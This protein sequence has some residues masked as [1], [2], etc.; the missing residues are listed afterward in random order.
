M[1]WS[2]L[3]RL[4]IGHALRRRPANGSAIGSSENQP[5]IYYKQGWNKGGTLLNC[6]L[7]RGNLFRNSFLK[8]ELVPIHRTGM[9]LVEMTC[10]YGFGWDFARS[11]E[12]LE[13]SFKHQ[14]VQWEISKQ[15][16]P[17][18]FPQNCDMRV[19]RKINT[20]VELVWYDFMNSFKIQKL[21]GPI[22]GSGTSSFMENPSSWASMKLQDIGFAG[23]PGW[24]LPQE[25]LGA[26]GCGDDMDGDQPTFHQEFDERGLSFYI[27]NSGK[28][29]HSFWK[30]VLENISW[31]CF[32]ETLVSIGRVASRAE[33]F[34]GPNP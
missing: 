1:K 26:A 6:V 14:P 18:H 12:E 33:H 30:V 31:R 8:G 5:V 3:A 28:C 11:L 21:G 23:R 9:D 25:T 34:F 27:S 7:T 15:S 29:W 17:G 13:V 19:T 32:A 10:W 2:P 22:L 4:Y 20:P 24:I 16:F